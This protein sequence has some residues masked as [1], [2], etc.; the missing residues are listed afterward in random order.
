MIKFGYIEGYNSY[1]IF[2]FNSESARD[3]AFNNWVEYSIDAY[4]PPYYTNVIK[5]DKSEVPQT[6]PI[7][8]VIIV[9]NNK[10]YYYYVDHFNYLNEDI[11]EIVI[12][13]DTITTFM[14]NFV[15]KQGLVTRKS[16]ARWIVENNTTKINRNYVRENVSEGIM[17]VSNFSYRN[18]NKY[19]IVTSSLNCVDRGVP[20]G[21]YVKDGISYDIGYYVYLFPLPPDP[22]EPLANIDVYNENNQLIYNS[23][24]YDI[25]HYFITEPHTINMMLVESEWLDRV[26]SCN[27]LKIEDLTHY[28]LTYTGMFND[29][30]IVRINTGGENPV[31]TWGID[32]RGIPA[33]NELATIIDFGFSKNTQLLRPFSYLYV[34][35]LLDENYIQVEYGDINGFASYPFHQAKT[36]RIQ[37]YN[38]LDVTNGN[39]GYYI[40]E[41]NVDNN[42]YN[43]YNISLG[44]TFDLITDPW[45][46][47]QAQNKGTLSTGLQLQAVNTLYSTAKSVIM[48]TTSRLFNQTRSLQ[49]FEN[50]Q[51]GISDMYA[52]Q[53]FRNQQS[54]V[55]GVSDGIM[56]GM[57]IIA[58]YQINRENL[59]YSPDTVKGRANLY[60]MMLSKYKSPYIKRYR[61]NDIE[62]CARKLEEFGYRV[63]EVFTG[64]QYMHNVCNIRRYYN[65]LSMKV[66]IYDVNKFIPN[67]IINDILARLENGLRFIAV[68]E[69]PEG[70]TITQMFDYDNV[71]R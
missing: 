65:C 52:N 5:V 3:R 33:T 56:Q 44:L 51:Q 28:K 2:K 59:E 27:W 46:E 39:N 10:Y 13:M 53:A 30:D 11:Y 34:P 40:I 45:L 15:V 19:I 38:S 41:E 20:R 1:N 54:Q 43:T 31:Y 29:D 12:N 4:Y 21:N 36:D 23:R 16:I 57:N 7:N 50:G 42:K 17:E 55:T 47:Y 18:G 63:N 62:N 68:D 6:T 26:Y 67:D 37:F 58:N 61:V 71:E 32:L 9:Y 48:P 22:L 14:Y 70:Y 35:Q 64:A 8:F 69:V 24:W 25:V 49:A 66:K 60:T